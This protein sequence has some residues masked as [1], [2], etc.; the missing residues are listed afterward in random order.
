MV[1]YESFMNN[2]SSLIFKG[3]SKFRNE[4]S[5]LKA[6]RSLKLTLTLRDCYQ[7]GLLKEELE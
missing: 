1:A 2:E 7:T 6:I 5:I 4:Y 3:N